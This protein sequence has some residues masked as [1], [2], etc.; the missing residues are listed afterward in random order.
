[1]QKYKLYFSNNTSEVVHA[2][3]L[4]GAAQVGTSKALSM[5]VRLISVVLIELN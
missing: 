1:M 5:K 4:N 2:H 3:C